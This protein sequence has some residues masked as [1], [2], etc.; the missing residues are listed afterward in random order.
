MTAETSV[1]SG[2]AGRVLGRRDNGGPTVGGRVRRGTLNTIRWVAILGQLLALFFTHFGLGYELPLGWALCAVGTS[3]LVNLWASRR[4]RASSR[5]S[6]REAALYLGF[7]LIELAALLYLTG[8]LNNPFAILILAPV[9][10]SAATLSRAT[11]AV[12]AVLAVVA[13]V[14]LSL[15]HLALPWPTPGF[16]LEPVFILGLAAALALST[17]FVAIYVFSVAE[18]ARRMSHALS[19]TQ[20]A[21]DREQQ[22]SALGAL[23]AAA[24]HELGSPLGTIAVVAKEIAR[25]LP[26]DS[27]LKDDV[28]LLL[29]QSERCRAILA[30]LAAKPEVG[31][32]TPFDAI[33]VKQLIET[34]AAPHRRHDVDLTIQELV[35]NSDGSTMAPKVRRRPEILHGL[36]TLLQNAIEFARSQVEVKA[37]WRD[38]QLTMTIADDGPGFPSDLLGHLGEP[39]LSGGDQGRGGEHMGLG[40]FIAETLLA[41]TGAKVSLANRR[42][43]G[44]QVTIEWPRGPLSDTD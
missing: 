27:P 10:V 21:L 20:M 42:E 39:Y 38:G 40:I 6:D 43:G 23:A 13:V 4:G 22:V 8:G 5:L 41:R 31:G 12:L 19:A 15:W 18:E 35:L 11:T 1:T 7:D 17:L 33:G 2:R 37:L 32:G 24:A 36:G 3:A 29:S 34:T 30:S 44:A 14:V 26:P 25:D 16:S 28:Q 9:T